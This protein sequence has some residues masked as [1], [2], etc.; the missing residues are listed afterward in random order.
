MEQ[1]RYFDTNIGL[2]T[3]INWIPEGE[4]KIA[5]VNLES[6]RWPQSVVKD[7]LTLSYYLIFTFEHFPIS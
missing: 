2:D 6:S 3:G 5:E 1:K 7:T 4:G